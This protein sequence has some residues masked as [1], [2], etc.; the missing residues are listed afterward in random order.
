M[1]PAIDHRDAIP[2]EYNGRTFHSRLEARWAVFFDTL[3]L[4]YECQ[5]AGLDWYTPD[6][7]LPALEA[8]IEVKPET[9]D[10]RAFA[11]A[12]QLAKIRRRRVF[13][14]LDLPGPE[15]F[16]GWY[17]ND[18]GTGYTW[19]GQDEDFVF[20]A[21]PLCHRV[22]I[23]RQALPPRPLACACPFPARPDLATL[24]RAYAVARTTRF[25]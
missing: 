17:V 21:C 4:A 20:V 13:M 22:A 5:P 14:V 6:F 19:I 25:A 7:W 23:R 11:K 16:Y 1:R 8:F 9:P 2:T 18:P 10:E 12:E 15:P 24:R 3:K